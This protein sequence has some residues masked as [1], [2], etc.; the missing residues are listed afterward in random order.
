[1]PAIVDRSPVVIAVSTGGCAPVLARK[2]KAQIEASLPRSLATLAEVAGSLRKQVK[3]RV[4]DSDARRR[5]WESVFDTTITGHIDPGHA[6]PMRQTLERLIDSG[7]HSTPQG[8]VCLIGPAPEDP[9][10]LTL[11]AFRLMQ[12]CD[13][14]LHDE[15]VNPE[16]LALTRAEAERIV[17]GKSH[18]AQNTQA[19]IAGRIIRMVFAGKRVLRLTAGRP[20]H[21]E[22]DLLANAGIPFHQLC[23]G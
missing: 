19:E 14:V 1:M 12:R 13:V 22:A 3:K 21:E 10:L 4:P 23:H 9:E 11:K 18:D 20:L 17:I 7:V 6:S 8:N 15:R 2:L 5:L 16:I